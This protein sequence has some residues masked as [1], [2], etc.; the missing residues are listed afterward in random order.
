MPGKNLEDTTINPDPR[1]LDKWKELGPLD[2]EIL[3]KG[4][5]LRLEKDPETGDFLGFGVICGEG[6]PI[7]YIG[8][9]NGE[10]E[11][12]GIGREI[13]KDGSI[14]EGQFSGG[15]LNGWAR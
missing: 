1:A 14:I 13:R 9:V 12:H 6:I 2:V 11:A 10:T 3:V 7:A 15:W 8:Q 4:N 5:L